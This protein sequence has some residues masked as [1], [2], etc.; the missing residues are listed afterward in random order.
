MAAAFYQSYLLK[1]N[2]SGYPDVY[3]A[4]TAMAERKIK[5]RQMLGLFRSLANEPVCGGGAAPAA[6]RPLRR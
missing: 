1:E 3:H 2:Q 4:I 6:A 5:R